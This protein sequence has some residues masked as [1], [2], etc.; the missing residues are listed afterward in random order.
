MTDLLDGFYG[1]LLIVRSS[2]GVLPPVLLCRFS[3]RVRL[4]TLNGLRVM[5]TARTRALLSYLS[6][7][8]EVRL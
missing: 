3:M 2:I 1:V 4:L 6:R 7:R 8:F 5:R